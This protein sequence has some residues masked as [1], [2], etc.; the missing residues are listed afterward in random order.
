M[1]AR[2]VSHWLPSIVERQECFAGSYFPVLDYDGCGRIIVVKQSRPISKY[3]VGSTQVCWPS[4]RQLF[5]YHVGFVESLK[6]IIMDNVVLEC[7]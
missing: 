1:A 3:H 6:P 7:Q 2:T 5:V 4:G